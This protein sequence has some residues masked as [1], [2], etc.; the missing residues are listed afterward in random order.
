MKIELSPEIHVHSEFLETRKDIIN[1]I[2]YLDDGLIDVEINH[3]ILGNVIEIFKKNKEYLTLKSIVLP[4]MESLEEV[5]IAQ[6][7]YN[8]FCLGGYDTYLSYV[9]P[10]VGYYLSS[11]N[12][13]Y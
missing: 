3:P 12:L 4:E 11:R 6:D 2:V 8:G 7:Y 5:E 9:H 13:N 1:K 10:E